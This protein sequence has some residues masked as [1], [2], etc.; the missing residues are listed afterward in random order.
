MRSLR[1]LGTLLLTAALAAASVTVPARAQEAPGTAPETFAPARLGVAE[2]QVSFWRAGA[3]GWVPARLNTALAVGDMIYSGDGGTVEV[4]I[5]S[6]DFVRLTTDTRLTVVAQEAGLLRMR[7]ESGTASL[8]LRSG[9][10]RLVEID[11]AAANIAVAGAGYYRVD[12]RGDAAHLTVR[13]GGRATLTLGDGRS[14]SV[15]SDEQIVARAG[16][17]ALERRPAPETDSWDR[18]NY[19][20]SDY[21]AESPSL[22]HLPPDMYGVADLDRNGSWRE[23]ETYGSVW[24]PAVAPG[25]APYSAGSWQWDPFYGWTWVDVAPWGWATS[26]YGRWV[27][28]GGY[29][30]WAPG[31]RVARAVYA[32]ALV[33]FFRGGTGVSWVALG[34]GEPLIPWWG[35]PGFRGSAWWGGWGGPR[36]VNNVVVRTEVRDVGTIV[37]RNTNVSHAVIGVRTEEFGRG[38][39]HGSTLPPPRPGELAVIGGDHPVAPFQGPRS[40]GGPAPMHAP[41]SPAPARPASVTPAPAVSPAPRPSIAPAPA[42]PM[43]APVAPTQPRDAGNVG[44]RELRGESRVPREQRFEQRMEPRA[45]PRMEPRPEQRMEPRPEPRMEQ[46]I[47]RREM[48]AAPAVR[49]PAAGVAP[50]EGRARPD[51][52]GRPQP[53]RERDRD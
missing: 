41:V 15:G 2:G 27:F 28:I 9:E 31:P 14:Q 16:S 51:H 45:E 35:R 53:P 13:R 12:L 10:T 47:E 42:A 50:S 24:V 20:R 29:W 4:Q 3:E 52:P 18:W 22:R 11:T 23:V 21:Y 38:H 34:W 32:P 8:D 7:V 17:G 19:A 30:A 5:G 49:A 1:L 25:W 39:V 26:H 6:R 48:P 44:Q 43:A 37:Y 40:A 36:I 46:R 33:A